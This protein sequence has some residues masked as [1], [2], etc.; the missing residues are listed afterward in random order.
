MDWIQTPS[1]MV[2]NLNL[3]THI[4]FTKAPGKLFTARLYFVG[5]PVDKPASLMLVD[6]D[7]QRLHDWF[8]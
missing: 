3:V 8:K 7:A 5:H 2:I 6:E 1:G 4:N